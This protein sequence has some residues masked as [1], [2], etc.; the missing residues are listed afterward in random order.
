MLICLHKLKEYSS[1]LFIFFSKFKMLFC[2]FCC[3]FLKIQ[4]IESVFM[5]SLVF[6][7]IVFFVLLLY[8]FN[9]FIRNLVE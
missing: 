1:K 3:N 2:Y 4:Y 6:S 7:I 5:F 9:L 8:S